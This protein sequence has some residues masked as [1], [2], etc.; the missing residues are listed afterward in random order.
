M[1]QR[2]GRIDRVKLGA[3]QS[4]IQ[5]ISFTPLNDLSGF[6]VDFLANDLKMFNRWRGDTTGIVTMP[7]GNKPNSAT[8]NDAMLA[9]NNAYIALY[10]TDYIQFNDSLNR[11]ESLSDLYFD[12]GIN[13]ISKIRMKDQQVQHDFQYLAFNKDIVNDIIFNTYSRSKQGDKDSIL[14]G[15]IRPLSNRKMYDENEITSDEL[16]THTN[17]LEELNN[18]IKKYYVENLEYIQEKN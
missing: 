18:S 4:N 17:N 10:N 14:F 8:F 2:I 15:E 16:N 7:L 1:E 11:I 5:I 3:E 9:L 6:M 13:K 12:K